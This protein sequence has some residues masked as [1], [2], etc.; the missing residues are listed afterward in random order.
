MIPT[1]VLHVTMYFLPESP[2]WLVS[3]DRQS[4]ALHVLARLHSKGDI[5]NPYV[6]AELAEIVAKI[7]WEKSNPPPTYGSM[8]FGSDARRTW[9]AIGVVSVH[10]NG[11]N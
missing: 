10:W 4:D 5:E 2:R 9:L 11:I 7:Q 3:Q 6:R 1:I 8:L